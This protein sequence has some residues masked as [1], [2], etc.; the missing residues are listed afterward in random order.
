MWGLSKDGNRQCGKCNKNLATYVY[1][2]DIRIVMS[3]QIVE[4]I[5]V[6][7]KDMENK[8]NLTEA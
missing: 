3:P 2:N 8:T 6:F 5:I 1:L 7:S 4:V